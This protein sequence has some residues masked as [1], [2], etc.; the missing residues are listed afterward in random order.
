MTARTASALA[1]LRE[2]ADL[3]PAV[4]STSFGAEDMVVLDL[5]RRQEL[6]ISIVTL[7]T[8]RLPE[9][10]YRLMQE[11]EERYGRCV[12][13]VFPDAEAIRR[14]VAVNG[15][16]GFYESIDK[17]KACCGVRKLEPLARVLAGKSA[18][19]TGQRASQAV[20]RAELAPRQRDVERGVE[21]FNPLFDWGEPDVWSYIRAEGVPYNE[22]HDRFYPSIGCAP[23]T[24]AIT[25]G[26]DIRAGRWW[27]ESADAKE[28]G[29]HGGKRVIQ[30]R[31][32]A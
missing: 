4:F 27:W 3:Q 16:N 8:G 12:Q 5:I 2:A 19:I 6:P 24:R 20:S 13:V 23:C 17:R 26:E 31:E 21:K 28:C 10:T 18:W 7:D 30:V 11:V 1:W 14:L 9:E 32:M 29:L 15:I 22:L 25:P